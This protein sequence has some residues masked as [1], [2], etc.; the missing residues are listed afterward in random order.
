M[1]AASLRQQQLQMENLRADFRRIDELYKVGGVSRSQW[2]ASKTSL[3]VSETAYRNLQRNTTLTSPI[4]GVVTARNYDNGD[5]YSGA[6]PVLTVAQIQPVKLVIN[7]SESQFTRITKGTK[8]EVELD[9]YPGET[10]EGTINLIHPTVN[11]TTRTF[12]A[13]VRLPNADQRVRPGMFGRVKLN[14]GKTE[15]IVVPDKAIIKQAGS[16]ERYVYVCRDGRVLRRTVE[17]GRRLG[18]RYELLSGLDGEAD[19]VVDGQYQ[20]AVKDSAQVEVVKN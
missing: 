3:D 10:F 18:D 5:M 11:A 16:G 13:E 20:S 6:Q 15:R 2:E 9:V 8:A 1:D 12:A 4:S 14:L 19:V 7:V 17:L